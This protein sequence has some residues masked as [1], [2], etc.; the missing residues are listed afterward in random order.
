MKG[1]GVNGSVV[2]T[3]S[4]DPLLDLYAMLNRGLGLSEISD[5]VDAV[6]S[7]GRDALT[8]DQK[9]QAITDLAVL[10]MQT[11]D[12]RGG[13]GEK[14]LAFHLFWTL[15]TRY[16]DTAK[17]L[18]PLFP[19]YGCYFDWTRM[20]ERIRKDRT[21]LDGE[22]G[23]SSEHRCLL[24]GTIE[25]A[26]VAQWQKD[27][28]S[29]KPS[30]LAK[31]LPR[32]KKAY[33]DVAFDLA[34]V[35]Y[36]RVRN[37]D[38]RMRKYRRDIAA[39]TKKLNVPETHMC[40]GTWRDISFKTVP[41]RCLKI[42][43][44]AFQNLTKKRVTRFPDNE[45][46][47]ACAANYSEFTEDIKEGKVVAH[48]ANVVFPHEIIQELMPAHWGNYH[49][50]V[51]TDQNE[52]VLESQFE[53]ITRRFATGLLKNTVVMC[54]VSGS[55]SG[56][57]VHVC[58]ALGLIC[59]SLNEGPFKDHIITF[60]S[61]PT[62]VP[63]SPL[64]SLR[65]KVE[66]LAKVPWGCSTNLEK[67]IDLMMTTTRRAKMRPE[68]APKYLLVITDMG[69]DELSG[70]RGETH[71]E[72]IKQKF[73]KNEYPI[74]TIVIWNVRA[75]FKQFSHDAFEKGV[76]TLSGWSPSILKMFEQQEFTTPYDCV[77]KILDDARYDPV[78]AAVAE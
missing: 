62:L 63:V 49:T 60:D 69:F 48:G 34:K 4:G 6:L 40:D 16:P 37:G 39:V 17:K 68:D 71:I 41:G 18:I 73:H 61:K 19:E 43:S 3:K 30:L 11:R 76:V 74:P 32:E 55:M 1:R 51:V 27:L 56:T 59:A 72:S 42:H 21:A 35:L 45:D 15:F 47:V 50:K 44:L 5:A 23:L 20:L 9:R 22:L 58:I 77:R 46:R 52:T 13:K 57:P 7:K 67:A 26:L 64:L 29:D 54:D 24:K 28:S 12:V 31:W 70:G 33:S 75:A 36:P 2:Y 8:E 78:R 38:A 66:V 10:V 53:D 65:K 25:K 14:E